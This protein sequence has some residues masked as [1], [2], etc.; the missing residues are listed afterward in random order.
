[1]EA[2]TH[3]LDTKHVTAIK[4]M[5][6]EYSK[7]GTQS[8][9]LTITKQELQK[10]LEAVNDQV[11][12]LEDSIAQLFVKEQLLAQDLEEKYGAGTLDLETN[13]FTKK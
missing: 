4:E 1:M 3:P 7:L 13:T 10:Q 6:E 11:K 8:I 12:Q 2:I 5:R 9:Q